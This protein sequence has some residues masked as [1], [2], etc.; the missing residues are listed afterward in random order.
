MYLFTFHVCTLKETGLHTL[1]YF[2]VFILKAHITN[3]KYIYFSQ[4]LNVGH[5]L[6]MKYVYI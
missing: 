5:L 3:N 6:L 4:I 1:Q 2:L